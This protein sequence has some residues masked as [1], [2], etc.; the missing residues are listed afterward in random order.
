MDLRWDEYDPDHTSQAL[1]EYKRNYGKDGMCM[2]GFVLRRSS[3]H[4]W[5]AYYWDA[6][7]VLT[8]GGEF[9]SRKD[10][11]DYLFSVIRLGV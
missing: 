5:T 3:G 2:R 10:A 7:S 9:K 1:R 6:A 11:K 4:E 8:H